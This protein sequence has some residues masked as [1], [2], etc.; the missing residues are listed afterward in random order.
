VGK[1]AKTPD[2]LEAG[3]RFGTAPQGRRDA[4][5]GADIGRT[6]LALG[7]S[8]QSDAIRRVRVRSTTSP[9]R[10][11]PNPGNAS[12]DHPQLASRS[13]SAKVSSQASSRS[14][15]QRQIACS[16]H[17]CNSCPCP[18]GP[19]PM[20]K[21][22]R[23]SPYASQGSRGRRAM[24]RRRCPVLPHWHRTITSHGVPGMGRRMSKDVVTS[25]REL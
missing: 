9:L 22:G 14:S 19:P 7:R 21:T 3:I 18:C 12:A 1:R 15:A 6:S 20:D 13:Q 10:E 23:S 8:R 2:P 5:S 25:K 24:F 11:S 4:T 17:W 16:V